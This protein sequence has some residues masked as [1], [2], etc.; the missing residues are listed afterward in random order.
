MMN[1][2]FKEETWPFWWLGELATLA[3]TLRTRCD[4][5]LL[6]HLFEDE[7][8]D[9][10]RQI[11]GMFAVALWDSSRGM[12]VLA[13]DRMGKK[14]FVYRHD[15]SRFHFALELAAMEGERRGELEG[16]W[17]APR[18]AGERRDG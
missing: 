16:R 8:R 2:T 5:E 17:N 1:A 7:S 18:K 4:T 14:P 3:A 9:F 15:G 6:P 11:D 10:V 12:G 13:R